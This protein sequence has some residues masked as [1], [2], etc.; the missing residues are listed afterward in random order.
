VRVWREEGK[1]LYLAWQAHTN[2]VKSLAFSPDER[3]LATS[4]WDGAIKLWDLER[5]ALLW[6][7]WQTSSIQRLAFAPDGRTLAS[8]G[9]DA[10]IRLWDAHRGTQ[11]QTLT[12]H[13]GPVHALAWSSDGRLLAS[14]G[15]DQHIRLG[16]AS[17][18]GG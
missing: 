18:D 13:S 1:L 8:G 17:L 4:S 6:T 5:G 16:T 11:L 9:D 10:V 15:F 3:T 7:G 12:G 14:A 2:T